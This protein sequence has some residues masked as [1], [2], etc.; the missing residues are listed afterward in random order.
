MRHIYIYTVLKTIQSI[1]ATIA[2][3]MLAIQVWQI[4][5]GTI[6]STHPKY[7]AQVCNT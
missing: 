5:A 2:K 4:D 6:S 1:I 7:M 3:E